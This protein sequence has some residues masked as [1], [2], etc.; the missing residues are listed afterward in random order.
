MS[1]ACR[2]AKSSEGRRIR[3]DVVLLFRFIGRRKTAIAE[4]GDA[5]G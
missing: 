4:K 3:N 5:V 1:E 2:A